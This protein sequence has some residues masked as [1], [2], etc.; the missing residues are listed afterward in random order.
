MVYVYVQNLST[1]ALYG[2]GWVMSSA[3]TWPQPSALPWGNYRV[4]VQVYHSQCGYS[5]WSDPQDWTVGNCTSKPTL[6]TP[7]GN[8]PT[9]QWDGGTGV[10]EY[11]HVY[12]RNLCTGAYY[13]SDWV[14]SSV[15]TWTQTNP[16]PAGYY[17]AWVQVYHSQCG[18]SEWSDPRDWGVGNASVR[19]YNNL[20]CGSTPFTATFTYGGQAFNA[21]SGNWSSCDAFAPGTYSWSLYADAGACGILDW[22]GTEPVAAGIVYNIWL[23]LDEWD[24]PEL[25]V[26]EECGDCGDPTP[27][28]LDA[29]G[30][31]VLMKSP[32]NEKF[33][34]KGFKRAR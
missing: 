24:E 2:S 6:Q 12:V 23:G 27:W 25:F 26:Y 22:S 13:G 20:I 9:Y 1:G 18:Y 29:T 28:S 16:L 5:E 17:R 10:W 3:N 14:N 7:S 4:Y 19:F 30:S 34:L 21:T 32:P 15:N 11:F 8:Q 33:P 31:R